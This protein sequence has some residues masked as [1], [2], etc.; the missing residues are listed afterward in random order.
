MKLPLVKSLA[1][2][3]ALCLLSGCIVLSVYPFYNGKDL[4]SDPGLA[5][6]WL[7]AGKTNEFW[8]FTAAGEKAY[9][10]TT[11]DETSTNCFEAHLFQLE[12]YQFLD[13][14]TTNREMFQLPLHLV[15]KFNRNETNLALS[16]LDYGWLANLLET[17]RAAVRH[18]TVPQ[19]PGNTNGG[20]MVYLTS[21]TREL[22]KF[23]L[24][25]GADTNAFSADSLV[26]LQRAP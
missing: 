11:T 19:E 26:Q 23:L 12:Q 20:N 25:Y 8:Q 15:S 10:L 14:L 24:K 2:S 6:R 3:G 5:G 13:L 18:L 1:M 17:N 21:T 4:T 9:L 7:K 16:F 22:Q